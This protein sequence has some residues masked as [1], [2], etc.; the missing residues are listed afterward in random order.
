MYWITG[1]LVFKSHMPKTLEK[2]MLFINPETTT[3]W[4]LE[5]NVRPEDMDKFLVEHGA[6]V[7]PYILDDDDN[8]LLTPD[9]IGW[10]D[11]GPD[12]DELRDITVDDFNMII[13]E[14]DEMID[15]QLEHEA[16]E[17][18]EVK[19]AILLQEGKACLS[20][21]M[22]ISMEDEIEDAEMYNEEDEWLDDSE[23]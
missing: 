22:Y 1:E 2:G 14:Y 21:P 20:T 12:T 13:N 17:Y 8:V 3:I 16:E 7:E 5:H 9:Q 4:A 6:P 15:I 23:G 18:E 11:D 10:W 19:E